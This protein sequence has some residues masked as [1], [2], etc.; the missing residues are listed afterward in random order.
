MDLAYFQYLCM[1]IY[2]RVFLVL[3]AS[4]CS[5]YVY[6]SSFVLYVAVGSCKYDKKVVNKL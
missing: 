6:S 2:I 5:F 4:D 1:P 3:R